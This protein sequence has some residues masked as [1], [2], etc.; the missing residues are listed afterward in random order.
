MRWEHRV[1]LRAARTVFTTPGAMQLYAEQ[2]PAL[3]QQ[4]RLAVIENGYDEEAFAGLAT[5]CRT[6]AGEPTVLVHSGVLYPEGRNPLPFFGALARLRAAGDIAEDTLRVVLRASGSEPIYAREL[7]RLGLQEM[8]DLAPAV[9]NR[10]ALAEQASADGLLLFQGNPYDRQIPAKVYEYLRTGR[11]IFA[12]VGEHGDTAALLRR[13][14]GAELAPLDDTD[15]IENS[16]RKFL[17]EVRSG[18]APRARP[19]AVTACSRRMGASALAHVL[20]Q[21]ATCAA[22]NGTS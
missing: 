6:P 12:L 13:T 4:G 10:E 8:V 20:N 3:A 14:D 18:A 2:Y 21:L 15:A 16:L 17:G 9:S 11:P 7:Q 5:A 1:V 22:G 19:E